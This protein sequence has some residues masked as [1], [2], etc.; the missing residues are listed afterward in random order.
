MGTNSFAV[1]THV[2][3]LTEAFIKDHGDLALEKLDGEEASFEQILGAIESLPFLAT[4]KMVVVRDLSANKPA[5]EALEQIVD[6]AGDTTDLILVESKLDKRGL[7]YKA[8]KKLTDFQ[9]YDELN[10]AELAAWL[11]QAARQQKAT[12][13][14]ADADYMVQR[15]GANQMKLSHELTKLVQYDPNI[16]RQTIQLLTDET[17]SSTIFNL[18]DNVFS[19]NLRRALEIYDEQRQQ[20][21]E[22]QAILGMLVWQMH[23]VAV[24]STAP[25]GTTPA[26]ISKDS[27][28]SPFVVQ[29]SQRIARKM[30]R[31]KILEFMDLL[32]DIDYRGKHEPLDYDEALKY[33]FV[34]LAE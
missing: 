23:A 19:G 10:E 26:Q 2:D 4:K 7:Y 8:L 31:R 5:A 1:K 14:R 17:P 3:E 12:L 34:S 9:E 28:M 25:A 33:A 21:V 22:P 6:R 29:K 18:V 32:R 15:I 11:M 24:A 30:G 27:G 20:K 16:T 13:S